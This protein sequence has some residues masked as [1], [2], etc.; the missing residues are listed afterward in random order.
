MQALELVAG[1]AVAK[2]VAHWACAHGGLV[3][4]NFFPL[5]Y[6]GL[7]LGEVCAKVFNISRAVAVPVMLGAVPG[8]LL[9]APLTALSFPVGLFVTGPVQTVPILVAIVTASMPGAQLNQ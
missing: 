5:L 6:Y 7:T 8:A 3:G 2:C 9:P 1:A 4:G